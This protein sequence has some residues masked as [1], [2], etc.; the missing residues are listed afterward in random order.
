MRLHELEETIEDLDLSSKQYNKLIHDLKVDGVGN[1][2]ARSA[3]DQ[4][5]SMWDKGDRLVGN[6]KSIIKDLKVNII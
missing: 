6:Y 1:K 3:K 2:N 5:M 4:I